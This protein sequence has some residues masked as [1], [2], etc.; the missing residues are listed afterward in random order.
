[1]YITVTSLSY[2]LDKRY[3]MLYPAIKTL[4]QGEFFHIVTLFSSKTKRFDREQL[5]ETHET[6]I[7]LTF[8]LRDI[9]NL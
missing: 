2:S 9:E 7:G 6:K 1:M 3:L 5:E 4:L 8:I